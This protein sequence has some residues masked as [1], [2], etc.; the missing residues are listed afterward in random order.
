M[1]QRA[2]TS[3]WRCRTSSA[4]R[5]DSTAVR[6]FAAGLV[7]RY[8]VAVDFAIHAPD[9]HGDERNYHA[10]VLMTTR[11]I[12]ANGFGAK[13]RELESFRTGPREIEAIRQRVGTNRQSRAGTSRDR[14]AASTAAAMPIRASTARRRC[15]WARSPRAWSATARVPISATATGR[16]RRATPSA[17]GSR[18][19][20][21]R[22]RPRSSI[23]RPSGSGG[24]KRTNCARAIR[25][26]SPPRIL[27]A[28]TE[29]RSTFSRGDLN[30]EL[31]KVILDPQERA[32]LTDR[33]LALPEVVGLQGDR[34]GAGLALHDAR[35]AR[36]T[37][38][39]SCAT[40]RPWPATPGTG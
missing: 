26:G 17:S 35:G 29:R 3:F 7:D 11:R 30:R 16:P 31:A 10:H 22:C 38:P 40:P 5:S 24:P 14:R 33:I 21:R 20:A 36:P 39:G 34:D 23:S 37:K 13:T 12:G 19:T 6:E 27:E 9:R 4:T 2:E 15:I 8:G 25:S 1:R 32:A 18:A 28:L